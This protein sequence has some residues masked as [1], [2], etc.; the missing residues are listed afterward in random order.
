[1]MIRS[2]KEGT[3]INSPSIFTLI[4]MSLL[5]RNPP[6]TSTFSLFKAA[7]TSPP[8]ILFSPKLVPVEPYPY[9]PFP[10]AADYDG[11]DTPQCFKARL[12]DVVRVGCHLLY[13][14]F[15]GDCNPHHGLGLDIE[16]VNR[17][18]LGIIGEFP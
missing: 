13:G 12:Y 11:T 4:S 3:S 7:V 8:Q 1:M 14:P 6:A 2:L 10:L 18:R 15:P 9:C 17:R 5:S 16:L